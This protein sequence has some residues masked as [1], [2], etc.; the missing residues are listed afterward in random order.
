MMYIFLLSV[1]LLVL[2]PGPAVL[3]LAGIG[4][5]YGYKV[6]LMFLAGLICAWNIV[7][8]VVVSGLNSLI[9]ALPTAR[10]VLLTISVIYILYLAYQIASAG[11]K[12][13]FRN[14]QSYPGFKS[15]LILNLI[16]PKA[17]AVNSALITGFTLFPENLT[18]ELVLKISVMNAIW[19][20][21]HLG[22]LYAGKMLNELNLPPGHQ[23]L[24][25]YLMAASLILVIMSSVISL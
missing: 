18:M 7:I 8:F 19:I 21:L 14:P 25:N 4:A 5:S 12:I 23:K 6:G 15:G 24:I 3:T 11:N 1:F 16:N 20:P 22:W 10:I 9:L 17:Y 13:S 2:T